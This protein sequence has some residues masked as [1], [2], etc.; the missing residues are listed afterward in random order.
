MF[1][2][3]CPLQRALSKRIHSDTGRTLRACSV[4]SGLSV[5]RFAVAATI[6][7]GLFQEQ[8]SFTY[9]L[10]ATTSVSSAAALAGHR[11]NWP[12]LRG[13]RSS[14]IY[15]RRDLSLSL[16]YQSRSSTSCAS[17]VGR[18]I[19]RRLNKLERFNNDGFIL[20]LHNDSPYSSTSSCVIRCGARGL[21]SMLNAARS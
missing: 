19:R 14:H 7:S 15:L 6:R 5:D 1:I 13:D 8:S 10:F 21:T 18:I 16:V 9:F 12:L 4:W 2:P 17:R 20:E 3:S 11:L